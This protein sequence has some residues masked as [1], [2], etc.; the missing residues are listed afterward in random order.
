MKDRKKKNIWD[1]SVQLETK[2]LMACASQWFMVGD[3]CA[4]T[5]VLC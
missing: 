1:I 3:L 5:S 2:Q 4:T